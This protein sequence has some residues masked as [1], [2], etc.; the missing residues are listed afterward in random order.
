MLQESLVHKREIQLGAL[1]TDLVM[2]ARYRKYLRR[3]RDIFDNQ[4]PKI[5]PTK[6]SD[7]L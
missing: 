4:D 1:D 5:K 7:G 2:E 6:V 3:I